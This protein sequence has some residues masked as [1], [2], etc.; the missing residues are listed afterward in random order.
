MEKF[1]SY[2]PVIIS[3]LVAFVIVLIIG[4][5]DTKSNPSEVYK[6]Y[7]DGKMIGAIR[8]KKAL[9]EYINNEQKSLKKEYDVDKVY[10]PNGIDIEKAITY[11]G[12]ILS[13]KAVYKKIK[14][15]KSFTI[16]GY[17]VSI[18]KENKKDIKL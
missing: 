16:K 9:E 7:I 5:K 14:A 4:F 1:K 6:V 11:N 12:K 18:S 13:E 8:S 15:K 2:V 17:V 3:I 10:I